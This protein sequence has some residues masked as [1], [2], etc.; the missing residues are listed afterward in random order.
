MSIAKTFEFNSLSE[1][2]FVCME[3]LLR[4]QKETV[5]LLCFLIESPNLSEI[6]KVLKRD[7]KFKAFVVKCVQ[8]IVKDKMSA[9]I[10]NLKLSIS[11]SK[12]SLD[13]MEGFSMSTI[14][15]K[16]TRST[17]NLQPILRAS[18]GS[19]SIPSHSS[20]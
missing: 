13:I 16:Y 4:P 9:V 12:I 17:P 2:V 11:S 6:L 3:V 15:N 18:A 10:S 8:D 5:D 19:I 14:D 1:A 20:Y 7:S